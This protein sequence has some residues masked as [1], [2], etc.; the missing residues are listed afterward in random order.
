MQQQDQA[1]GSIY[2]GQNNINNGNHYLL[3]GIPYL[4]SSTMSAGTL[5]VR[6]PYISKN[7][8]ITNTSATGSGLD[9][10]VG[11]TLSGVTSSNYFTLTPQQT[12]DFN[13]RTGFLYLS[14]STAPTYEVICEM[15]TAVHAP[16]FDLTRFYG[17]FGVS[18][19]IPKFV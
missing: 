17:T 14:S 11:F 13:A 6:F 15:S 2:Y 4:T 8:I 1:T 18:Y 12:L 3:P 19:S 10:R 9:M 16:D 7:I 5:E